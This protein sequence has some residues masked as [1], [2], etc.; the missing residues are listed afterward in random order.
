MIAIKTLIFFFGLIFTIQFVTDLVLRIIGQTKY[1]KTGTE[2]HTNFVQ[3]FIKPLAHADKLA[4]MIV[5]WTAFYVL[6]QVL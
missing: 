5:T 1:H 6:C 4:A 2:W 3:G